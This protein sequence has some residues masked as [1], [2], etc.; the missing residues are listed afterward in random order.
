MIITKLIGGLGNQ[1]FQYAVGRSLAEK[2][3]SQLFLDVTG[4]EHQ[5][6]VTPRQYALS[7]FNTEEHFASS[8]DLD[9]LKF[10]SRL[11]KL[12]HLKSKQYIKEKTL[13][14]FDGRI[15][16]LPD[17]TYLNGFWQTEKYFSMIGDIIRSEF[18]LRPQFN[19]LD[20][21][22]ISQIENSQSVSLHVR[23]GDYVSNVKTNL[24]H[25]VCSLDYYQNAIEFLKKTNGELKLFI[26]SDD[27]KWVKDNLKIEQ[28]T[29]FVSNGQLKDYEELMLMS[30]CKHQIIANSS[31]SWWGAWLNVHPAKKVIAPK[32]WFNNNSANY[33][34]IIPETWIRL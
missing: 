31:F 19:H 15:L 25:G 8:S 16:N 2:N 10:G 12:L 4:Y 18:S 17:N 24:Y 6:G 32:N 28:K 27:I 29:V 7:I 20:S 23:R 22:L 11:G 5:V 3:K 14:V 1:M 34:D 9:K 21:S 33:N 26:F 13:N 30:K